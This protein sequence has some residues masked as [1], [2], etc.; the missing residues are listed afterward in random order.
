MTRLRCV[1]MQRDETALLEGWLSHHGYLVG[2]ENLTVFDNGSTSR[3]TIAILRRFAGA[4][5][6]VIWEHRA[7]ADYAARAIHVEN[8]SRQW[9]EPGVTF[10]LMIECDERLALFS[11]HGLSCARGELDAYLQGPF[12]AAESFTIDLGFV[13]SVEEAG[14]FSPEPMAR[15]LLVRGEASSAEAMRRPEDLTVLSLGAVAAAERAAPLLIGLPSWT[16]LARA[17]DLEEGRAGPTDHIELRLPAPRKGR[18]RPVSA[19]DGA[20]YLA[21]NPD[22]AEAGWPALK[23]YLM[24][25]QLEGRQV[26]ALP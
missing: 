5:V 25:G 4:G 23:H 26:R 3:A 1:T 11:A 14:Y 2:F 20:A 7:D 6:R 12:A 19:F 9:T 13:A 24:R 17:L 16:N 8:L 10:G 21:L 18:K 15:R 22:V